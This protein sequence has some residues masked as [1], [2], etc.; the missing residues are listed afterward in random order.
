MVVSGLTIINVL[1]MPITTQHVKMRELRI[2]DIFVPNMTAFR[3]PKVDQVSYPIVCL[4]NVS[5]ILKS[6]ILEKF[7]VDS[8]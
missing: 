8:R 1:V 4:W 5:C 6:Q 7:N 3:I 2:H